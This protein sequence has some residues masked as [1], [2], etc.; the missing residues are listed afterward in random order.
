MEPM[1]GGPA[2]AIF[3]RSLDANINPYTV[4][5]RHVSSSPGGHSWGLLWS[6]S[7]RSCSYSPGAAGGCRR[8]KYAVAKARRYKAAGRRLQK[9]SGDICVRW[10]SKAWRWISLYGRT[11]RATV[12]VSGPV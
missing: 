12:A 7:N 1:G 2:Q 11:S 8:I 5:N 10:A 3:D 9:L 6:P 4:D